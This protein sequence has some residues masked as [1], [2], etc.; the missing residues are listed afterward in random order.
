MPARLK[1]WRGTEA[2]YLSTRDCSPPGRPRMGSAPGTCWSRPPIIRGTDLRDARVS[3]GNRDQPVTTFTLS[4][5]AARRFERYTQA[6]IG[7]RS[8]IVLDGEILS[9]P[10]IEDVIRDSGQIRGARTLQEAQDLAVN[11]R[12]GA[13]PAAIE[14]AQERIVEASL[15]ADSIRH[16]LQAG[17]AGLDRSGGGDAALLPLGRR[18]CNARAAVER[19]T[20]DRRAGVL[21][22][23]ADAAGNCRRGPDHRHGGGQQR[24]DLRANSRGTARGQAGR[25]S[26]GRRILEGIRHFGGYARDHRGLLRLPVLLRN[27][28]RAGIRSHSGAWTDHQSVHVGLRVESCLRLGNSA[29]KAGRG[30]EHRVWLSRHKQRRDAREGASLVNRYF[31]ELFELDCR[32]D[33][34]SLGA[35]SAQ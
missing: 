2:F 15:G 4:Q 6:N 29:A 14:V 13:L 20:V 22:S 28:R 3:A 8:A 17:A 10:V 24:A 35:N 23:G 19:R 1:R 16:G 25:G 33:T 26:A 12:A 5:D 18:Q 31:G 21:R 34:R 9:V 11:L 32:K 30:I 7:Q 27:S